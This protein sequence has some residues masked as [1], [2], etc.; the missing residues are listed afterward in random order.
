M[1]NS[2]F[3]YGDWLLTSDSDVYSLLNM[4][5]SNNQYKWLTSFLSNVKIVHSLKVVNGVSKTLQLGENFN[6]SI[7]Q[8]RACHL[9][10]FKWKLIY[11]EKMMIYDKS[12]I[13][14]NLCKQ[15]RF[16]MHGKKTANDTE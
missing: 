12:D 16:I 10:H 14:L 8:L 13:Y 4:S 9:E 3:Q 5:I 15:Y 6:Y 1:L 11:P 7:Q 2:L